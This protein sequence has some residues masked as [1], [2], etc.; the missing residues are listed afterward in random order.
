MSFF[1]NQQTHYVPQQLKRPFV[2][3]SLAFDHERPLL[4]SDSQNLLLLFPQ[5]S[6]LK[7]ILVLQVHAQWKQ[8]PQVS[9]RIEVHLPASHKCLGLEHLL[10]AH[11]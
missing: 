1:L 8:L 9:L 2:W 7:H 6:S 5:K 10:S 3:I 4:D 11:V